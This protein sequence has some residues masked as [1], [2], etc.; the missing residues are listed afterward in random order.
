MKLETI[1]RAKEMLARVL[2]DGATYKEA[3][4]P[5]GLARSTVERT[6]K[7]LVMQVARE[8]GIAGLDQDAL[9][10][11]ARLKHSREQ[12][13]SAVRDYLPSPRKPHGAVLGPEEIAAG[14]RK[15]RTR[16]ENANRDVALMYVLFCTGAKP[17]EIARLDV[18]DYLN[19]DGSVRVH[20][21]LRED[22]AVNGR[23]RPLFFTSARACAAIDAY[24]GERF[25]RKLGAGRAG[26][27]RGL[28][29]HSGLFLTEAGKRFEVSARGPNDS[30]ATC[31]LV[32][33]TYRSIFMRAGW[34]GVTAQSA[35][36][37]VA[38]RLAEKGAE[39]DQVGELLGLS[40]SRAVKRLLGQQRR[41]L[42]LLAL[43]LV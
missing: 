40:S 38:R 9:T 39:D 14:A 32:I 4:E 27:Y 16:S 30:R 3:G 35:R 11:L 29:P 28:D 2:E 43:E 31:R 22:A 1:G 8:C 26:E 42:E 33:A 5:Y 37:V 15:L 24:L 13:L 34:L 10:S 12:V 7:S 6:I 18:R 20:S 19:R 23:R 21:E 25:R 17:I 36:R 41:P